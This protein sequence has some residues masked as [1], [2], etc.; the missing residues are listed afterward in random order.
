MIHLKMNFKNPDSTGCDYGKFLGAPVMHKKTILII[1][2]TPSNLIQLNNFLCKD[3]WVKVANS[4]NRG[5]KLAMAEDAPDLILLDVVMPGLNGFQV[6]EVLKN[7]RKSRHI[8]IVFLTTLDREVEV[9]FGLALGAA[10]FISKPVSPQ[11]FSSKITACLSQAP[12]HEN[13]PHD[14][15]RRVDVC[16]A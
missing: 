16:S 4:G 7:N 12:R 13:D 1:D 9:Q 8:P 6:C 5:I 14:V 2:D 10:D 3:Y 15:S 11:E